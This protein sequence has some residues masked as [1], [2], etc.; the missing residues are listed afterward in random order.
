MSANFGMQV[1]RSIPLFTGL[2]ETECR[3]IAEVI[4]LHSFAM[5]ETVIRQGE[6]SRNLWVLL[7]GKCEVAKRL[8]QDDP[9][10]ESVLLA[11]IEP[12]Q[13]FGE[14]S[15]FHPAPHSADV[16]AKANVKVLRISHVDYQDLIAEGVW[17]AYKL[18]YN[19][20]NG[21]AERMRRM[22]QWVTDLMVHQKEAASQPEW[23]EFREKLFSGWNT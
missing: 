20:V 14:M 21:L 4:Q 15:F 8:S 23:S 5:G 18:A 10:S 7:E 19:V 12:Y 13:H 3:Q 2:N 11:T 9:D 6:S 1:L 16:R 22:D 17:A